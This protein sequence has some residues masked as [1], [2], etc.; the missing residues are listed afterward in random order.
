MIGVSARQGAAAR[1]QRGDPS[2]R[3][4]IGGAFSSLAL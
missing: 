4:T 3:A 1:T 2:I